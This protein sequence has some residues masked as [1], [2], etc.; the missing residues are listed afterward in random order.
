MWE[1]RLRRLLYARRVAGTALQRCWRAPLPATG[2]DWRQVSFLV[3]DAEMS[4]LDVN[5][6]ELLSVGWVAVEAGA[7][8]LGSARHYLIKAE[9]SV[10][11][12][13]TI[14]S[15]RDCELSGAET[16]DVVL[17]RFLDAAAG[18]VLVFHNAALD[19]A[20]LNRVS[21]NAFNAPVLLPAV[22]TLRQEERMLR[23]REQPIKT[24]DLRLHACRER[25]NLPLYQGHNALL[26]ALATAELLLAMAAHRSRGQ[27]LALGQ[28]L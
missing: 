6:G 16:G 1:L 21:R 18:R 25:Y 14:H 28:L 7:I 19:I 5:E 22:D 2:T 24:G 13:A 27:G 23:R 11:Q 26:D 10:G 4:S 8:A 9:K 12:S 3:V 17:E 15:L 20:F